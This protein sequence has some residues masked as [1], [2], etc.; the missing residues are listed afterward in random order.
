MRSTA[1]TQNVRSERPG[2]TRRNAGSVQVGIAEGVVAVFTTGNERGELFAKTF[3]A[4]LNANGIAASAQRGLLENIMNELIK[5]GRERNSP[6]NEWVVI[7]V[8]DK[9]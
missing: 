9:P 6:A 7:A 1:L 4:A 8:G 3:A 2:R 5:Q